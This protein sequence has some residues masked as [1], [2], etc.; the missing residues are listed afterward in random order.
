MIL[1]KILNFVKRFCTGVQNVL[2]LGWG[3]EVPMGISNPDPVEDKLFQIF[4]TVFEIIRPNVWP[5]SRES[6]PHYM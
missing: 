3:R 5:R 2:F 4:P 6:N 1:D